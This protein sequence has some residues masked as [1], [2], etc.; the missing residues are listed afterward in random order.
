MILWYYTFY[1]DTMMV[2]WCHTYYDGAMMVCNAICPQASV[3]MQLLRRLVLCCAPWCDTLRCDKMIKKSNWGI[4]NESYS[5]FLRF[6]IRCCGESLLCPSPH[7]T[8]YLP[9]FQKLAANFWFVSL[10]KMHSR[11]ST[12]S[13]HFF[14]VFRIDDELSILFALSL[15]DCE[16]HG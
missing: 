16:M 7:R 8:M 3:I 6:V 4:Q 9:T 14:L 15:W 1:V 13:A 11:S 10:C 12:Q 5:G 2:L